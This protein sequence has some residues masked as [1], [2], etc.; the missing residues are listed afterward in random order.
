M[1]TKIYFLSDESSRIFY[2]GKTS[3]SLSKRLGE[4]LRDS[5]DGK[6]GPR[7][8]WIRSMLS[9]GLL[10]TTSLVGEVDGNGCR[11]EIG[12]IK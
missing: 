12:W 2:I 8:D 1:K 4:H 9:R 7:F 5:R 6:V 10:P 11:E 3:G